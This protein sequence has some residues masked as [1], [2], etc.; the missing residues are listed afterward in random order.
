MTEL[1]SMNTI[2]HISEAIRTG[3]A[4]I[5]DVRSYIEFQSGHVVNA[6]NIPL[7]EIPG[8]MES[9]Q[10]EERLIVLCCASGNRSAQATAFLQSQGV[11]NVVNG[12]SWYDVNFISQN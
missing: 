2:N 12:G 1:C 10:Q 5:I 8:H 9:L 3:S 6:E 11:S 7:Q 4:R